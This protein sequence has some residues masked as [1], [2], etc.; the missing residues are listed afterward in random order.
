[1]LIIFNFNQTSRRRF[2]KF[3]GKKTLKNRLV[4]TSKKKKIIHF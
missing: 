2:E 3:A 4:A 1:M